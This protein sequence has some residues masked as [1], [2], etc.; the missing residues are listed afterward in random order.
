MKRLIPKSP[1]DLSSEANLF[2]Y[3]ILTSIMGLGVFLSIFAFVTT[4]HY[5]Y[6][7]ALQKFRFNAGQLH[8]V[9]SSKAAGHELQMKLLKEFLARDGAGSLRWLRERARETR[10][11]CVS[12]LDVDPR[13]GLLWRERALKSG[14]G[15]VRRDANEVVVEA[16]QL[17]R[18]NGILQSVTR[19]ERMNARGEM[20]LAVTLPVEALLPQDL[21]GLAPEVG[22][23]LAGAGET[24]FVVGKELLVLGE[25]LHV[26]YKPGGAA[27]ELPL[28]W[29][30]SVLAVGVVITLLV[31]AVVYSLINRNIAVQKVVEERTLDLREATARAVH[32]NETKSRFL[33]N[34]SHEVRTPLN[35]IMGMAEVLSETRITPEQKNYV[36]AMRR[37]GQHLLEMLNDVLDV[38]SIEAGEVTYEAR[39]L[40]LVELVENVSDFV[41][42][43][44]RVKKL[45][46]NHDIDPRV[47]RRVMGDGK[48]LRQILINLINNAMKFTDRGGITLRVAVAE[49][50]VI[51]MEVQDTGIGIPATEVEKIFGEF[52]QVDSSS[53]RGRA[54]VGLGLSIVKT[55]V[56]HLKG[57]VEVKS[58]VGVGS[59]F[60]VRLPLPACSPGVS[61][62][63]DL[64][65]ATGSNG[66]VLV[67]SP[68]V[69]RSIFIR[70]TLAVAGYDVRVIGLGREALR[71]LKKS[72]DEYAHLIVDVVGKDMGGMDVLKEAKLSEAELAR[73]TVLC[74]IVHRARDPEALNEI[75]IRRICYTPVKIRELVATMRGAAAVPAAEKP[76]RPSG[77]SNGFRLLVAEDDEDNRF[78]LQTYLASA[79]VEVSFA[80]DGRAALEHY[81]GQAPEV[82]LLLTDIQMPKMDGFELIREVR[83]FESDRKLE[84]VKIVA[85]TADA[86]AEQ[87]ERVKAAGGNGYLT[88]P[89]SKAQLLGLLADLSASKR[90]A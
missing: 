80:A 37:A 58:E 78:L 3:F 14:P 83:K 89:I 61:W 71:H 11:S 56:E 34:V 55:Y 10:F 22:G 57:S 30:W 73:T 44:C 79:G 13:T 82:D 90:A 8:S 72:R 24:D 12:I 25:E 39:E 18:P 26:T 87:V 15:C 43:A 54:G 5:Q 35:L 68:N 38:A 67:V 17:D 49:G 88:K 63:D 70:N 47:P 45:S 1:I 42:V 27:G 50:D 65:A 85:L 77:I 33:A 66:R 84:K 9:V 28:S 19:T 7:D 29:A 40:D 76:A 36:E 81:K 59:S 20:Y 53:R 48:R 2:D 46:Y 74:P 31:T 21:G 41:S 23:E 32:A 51:V 64:K 52:Y 16:G 6:E 75:G 4:V 69:V 62:L 60:T 86:Q